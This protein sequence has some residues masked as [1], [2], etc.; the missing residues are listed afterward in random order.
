M[1]ARRIRRG[2]L[3][4]VYRNVTGSSTTV[5]GSSGTATKPFAGGVVR[6][7]VPL[8]TLK[9]RAKAFVDT[10][11]ENA[12]LLYLTPG[13]GQAQE[14]TKTETQARAYK[15]AGYPTPFDTTAQNSTYPFVHAEMLAKADA[16]LITLSNQT[17]IDSAAESVTDEII[18]EADAYV[19]A[20]KTI[21]RLRREAKIKIDL[22]TTP[23]QI[24]SALIGIAWP[25]P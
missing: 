14:Y 2:I 18:A 5:T 16:G 10:A 20:G 21:K 11:A 12:R 17:E 15:A 22:A 25:S 9:A 23:G 3:G 13:A 7:G 4:K 1:P 8:A 19:A 6:Y 24:R